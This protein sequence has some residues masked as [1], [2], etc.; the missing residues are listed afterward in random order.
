MKHLY[1]LFVF[2]EIKKHIHMK[3]LILLLFTAAL[4]C[5]SCNNDDDNGVPIKEFSIEEANNS[6]INGSAFFIGSNS[7]DTVYTIDVQ[8][9]GAS[10]EESY[11]VN[12]Y[13]NSL[14]NGGDII[15]SF[16]N[17]QNIEGSDL[18]TSSTFFD[19][20]NQLIIEGE[21]LKY[22]ELIAFDGHIKIFN[23]IDNAEP[24]LVAEGNIGINAQ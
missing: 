8:L 9:M 24:I 10:V 13:N 5:T 18:I 19:S 15:L 21:V 16:D 3:N 7:L 22:S 20:S 23:N 4:F 14:S 6:G 11:T 17:F 1:T 2:L 12:I